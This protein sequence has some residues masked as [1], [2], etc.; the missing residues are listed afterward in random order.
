M[1][2]FW[3]CFRSKVG[4]LALSLNR[5]NKSNLRMG[6]ESTGLAGDKGFSINL[7]TNFS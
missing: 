1:S 3:P 2:E 4:Q 6:G 7:I 5:V